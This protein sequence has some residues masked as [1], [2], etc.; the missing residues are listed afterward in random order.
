[1]GVWM[2]L[3]KEDLLKRIGTLLDK[4]EHLVEFRREKVQRGQNPPIWAQ[5]ISLIYVN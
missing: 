5:V 3:R 1:M 4:V 2:K